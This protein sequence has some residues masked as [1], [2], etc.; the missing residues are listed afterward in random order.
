MP[1]PPREA[2][3]TPGSARAN[4]MALRV[5]AKPLDTDN[6]GYPDL[7]EVEANL[8]AQPYPTPIHE[9]GAFVFVLYR[10]GE[11]GLAEAQPL[12]RWRIE[13]AAQRRSRSASD[14][15]GPGYRFALSLLDAGGDAMPATRADL[16]CWFESADG[17]SPVQ[18]RGVRSIQVGRGAARA[19]AP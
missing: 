9:D 10:P 8:F 15:F 18:S 1:D 6:N 5:G 7:I 16:V 11:S 14:L 13:G 12:A 2:P 17:G 3:L 19:A 4:A